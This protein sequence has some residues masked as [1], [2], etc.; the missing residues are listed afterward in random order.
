MSQLFGDM[1]LLSPKTSDSNN[2]EMLI[3]LVFTPRSNL[4]I[5]VFSYY[6]MPNAMKTYHHDLTMYDEFK[7]LGLHMT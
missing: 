5:D 2:T 3:Y 4:H 6:A 7:L 1:D